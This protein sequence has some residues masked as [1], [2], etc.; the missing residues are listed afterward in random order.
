[1]G[2][3]VIQTKGIKL[4]GNLKHLFICLYV[5]FCYILIIKGKNAAEMWYSE[6]SKHRYQDY[7]KETSS[8]SQM[9]WA[10]TQLVGFGRAKSQTGAWYGVALYYPEGNIL[11]LFRENVFP[12]VNQF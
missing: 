7:Q 4:T 2:E 9:V 1:L 5:S 11:G 10:N 6:S 12:P 8:F 3:N